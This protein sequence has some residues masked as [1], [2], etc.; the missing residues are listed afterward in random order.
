MLNFHDIPTI[1][2][3]NLS[4]VEVAHM[5]YIDRSLCVVDIYGRAGGLQAS[6]RMC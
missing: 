5:A 3:I 6:L 2:N 1:F 4:A